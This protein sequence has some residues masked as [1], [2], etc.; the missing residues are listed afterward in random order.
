MTTNA[1]YDEHGSDLSHQV[2][3]VATTQWLQHNQTLLLPA[4]GVA[5]E[6]NFGVSQ[7]C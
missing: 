6:T 2:S 5:C 3:A 1:M 7:V 4:K